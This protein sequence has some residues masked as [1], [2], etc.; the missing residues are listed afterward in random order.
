MSYS[1]EI[2]LAISDVKS[3]LLTAIKNRSNLCLRNS[4]SVTQMQLI[5]DLKYKNQHQQIIHELIMNYAIKS[6]KI[7]PGSFFSCIE[8]TL[9]SIDCKST[10][11][12][13]LLTDI[14]KFGSINPDKKDVQWCIDTYMISSN[15]DKKILENA[16]NLAGF[17]GRVIIEKSNSVDSIEVMKGYSF[18]GLKP[19]WDVNMHIKNCRVLCIDGFIESASE[20]H[21]FLSSASET[22]ETILLFI[23]GL[24]QDVL[25]TIRVNY[26]RGTI[27]VLPIIVPFDVFG[28]NMINDISIVSGCDLISSLKGDQITTLSVSDTSIIDE[29]IITPAKLTII[30]S[31]TNNSVVVHTKTLLEK[32]SKEKID[33]VIELLDKRIRSLSPNHVV[34]RLVNDHNWTSRVQAFDYTLRALRSLSDYGTLLIDDKKELASSFISSE[35]NSMNCIESLNQLGYIIT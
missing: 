12:K 2:V 24:S 33:D 32:R 20:I 14:L 8:K 27:K 35:I 22:N 1:D 5:F 10:P 18:E 19:Q 7:G 15:V 11:T 29:S 3:T 30:N 21:N 16:L 9:K 13:T 17:A 23:R 6:E 28:I 34:I 25:N 31:K 4:I 26:D